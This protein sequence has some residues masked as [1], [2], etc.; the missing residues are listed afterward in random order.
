MDYV[1]QLAFGWLYFS[2]GMVLCGLTCFVISRCGGDPRQFPFPLIVVAWPLYV[3]AAFL[4][5]GS[6]WVCHLVSRP[7]TATKE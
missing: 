1:W 2:I 6:M 4:F 5:F 7:T 3:F